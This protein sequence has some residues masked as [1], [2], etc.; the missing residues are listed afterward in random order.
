MS[1]CSSLRQQIYKGLNG[2][3][4]GLSMGL[5]K[6]ESVIDGVTRETYT[7]IFS[8]TGV[9]KTSLCLYS[10]VYRPIMDNL[11]NDNI[12]VIYF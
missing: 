10:Y 12:K 5:P 2:D 4:W 9:G 3:N 11:D 8:G 7:L 1:I 6:V